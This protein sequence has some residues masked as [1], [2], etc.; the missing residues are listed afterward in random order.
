MISVDVETSEIDTSSLEEL[1]EAYDNLSKSAESYTKVQKT[2]TDALKEQKEYGQLSSD[3]IRSLSEA[4]YALA[5]TTDKETGAVTL[6][7]KEYERLNAQKKQKLK[8][9]LEQQNT[10]L[11][12]KIK[13][14]ESTISSLKKEYEALAKANAE[15]NAERLKE[16]EIEITARS[17]DEARLLEL[18]DKNNATKIGLDASTFEKADNKDLWKEEAEKKFADLEHLYAMDKISYASY[19]NQMD[20]LNQHYYGNNE[21]YL[22]DFYKYEEKIYQGRKKLAEDLLAEEEKTQKASHNNRISEL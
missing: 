22:D 6:N 21:K 1:Q 5:L 8:L 11:Q 15:A 17:Q 4:G 14:E 18:V 19:L 20:K 16:I 3:S 13:E 12:T 10:D 2:L 9:D 7:V